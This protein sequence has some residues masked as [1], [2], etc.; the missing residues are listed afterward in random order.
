MSLPCQRLRENISFWWKHF[1]VKQGLPEFPNTTKPK[2]KGQGQGN[3]RAYK[4][5]KGKSMPKHMH[6]ALTKNGDVTEQLVGWA[7]CHHKVVVLWMWFE[8]I[9]GRGGIANNLKAG[10]SKG[11]T[12]PSSLFK[13]TLNPMF[14][15]PTKRY[16]L[17]PMDKSTNSYSPVLCTGS[18]DCV[19][20]NLNSINY[21]NSIN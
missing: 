14:P 8:A 15:E 17:F 16:A 3:K 10:Q 1:F 5:R 12:R 9:K 4:R 18:T 21:L 7:M 6:Q 2:K 20:N 13:V 19:K 11:P